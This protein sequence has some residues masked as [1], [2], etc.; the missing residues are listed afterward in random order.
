MQA[1]PL[2]FTRSEDIAYSLY[3][4]PNFA[5]LDANAAVNHGGRWSYLAADPVEIIE[6]GHTD[7]DPLSSLRALVERP[8]YWIG[9]I[10][11]D[12]A[13]P[14]AKRALCDQPSNP[15][16]PVVCFARYPWIIS[17]D[18]TRGRG[19]VHGDVPD[20]FHTVL[21]GHSMP[22]Q[23]QVGAVIASDAQQ[24]E[25]A[26]REALELI[27]AGQIYQVN[28]ARRWRADYDGDPFALYL[29]MRRLSPVPYGA[30]LRT[31][32]G[33]VLSRSMECFLDWE[34][35]SGVLRSQPIKGT[36]AQDGRA[37]S[38]L[39]AQLQN[40][41][42]ERAE[43][44]MIVDLMRNDL[45]RVATPHSVKV[46]SP[47]A[48]Y[49]YAGLCHMIS[50]VQCLTTSSTD[51]ESLFRA[52]FPPGSISGTPKHAALGVIERLESAPRGMFSGALGIVFPDSSAKFSVAIRTA[53]FANQHLE[54]WAGGG[55]V[56]ASVPERELR[57]TEVK[58]E[59]F[60]R[61]IDQMR[62]QE[63]RSSLLRSSHN[64]PDHP[65][66]EL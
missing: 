58:A 40:D 33:V 54:Y 44:T 34:G 16:L 55:I 23:P 19:F 31:H 32:H 43:H 8:G 3:H 7:S 11:Y 13:R 64:R 15:H 10:G 12:A 37:F 56:G 22:T 48:V 24:H 17:W 38:V 51:M 66:F 28:L 27:R 35:P 46:V 2:A 50:T 21:S 52:T 26:I 47:Y 39:Q 4:R 62:T 14:H 65:A 30:Y 45:S 5:W 18:H 6:I 59:V 41:A 63:T 25:N 53:T 61:A 49:P 60:L 1:K 36:I 57:E 42:K 9:W 29:A 20:T